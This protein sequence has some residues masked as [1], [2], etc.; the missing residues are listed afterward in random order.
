MRNTKYLM[1]TLVAAMAACSDS[2]LAPATDSPARTVDS[3]G[4][5]STQSLTRHDTLEFRITIDPSRK[6]VY[7]LGDGNTITFPA[8]SLCDPQRSSYG[9]SEWDKPCVKATN[10]LTVNVTAWLDA[11]GHSRVDFDKHVRFVP[12]SNPSQWVVITFADAEASLDP[13]FNILYCPSRYGKCKDESKRDASLLPV[14]HPL[15][16]KITRRIKHFSGYNV[17]A[18]R[19]AEDGGGDGSDGYWSSLAPA[20]STRVSSA[21]VAAAPDARSANARSRLSNE[22]Q[23]PGLSGYILASG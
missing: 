11:K 23:S 19:D 13:F 8:G 17:A 20:G 16:G 6:T 10:P 2:P 5:G 7:N 21:V 14:K 12:S 3:Y 18:G 1:L 9:E 22:A 15:S 4:V